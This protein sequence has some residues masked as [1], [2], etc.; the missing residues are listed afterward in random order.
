MECDGGVKGCCLVALQCL[1]DSD[2]AEACC[3]LKRVR[4][5]GQTTETASHA[6]SGARPKSFLSAIINPQILAVDLVD[7]GG[8]GLPG[9]A[10]TAA[11]ILASLT[12]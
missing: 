3:S 8:D 10:T 4:L 5:P 7:N 9:I 2:R 12:R 1:G 6:T 11:G